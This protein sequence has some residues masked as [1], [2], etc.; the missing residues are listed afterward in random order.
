M[1]A[2]FIGLK[3]PAVQEALEGMGI[4]AKDVCRVIIDLGC[5][6]PA[7]VYVELFASKGPVAKIITAL[8]PGIGIVIVDGVPRDD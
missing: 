5:D 7:R 1:S 3:D 2:R 6:Y 4:D 8:C